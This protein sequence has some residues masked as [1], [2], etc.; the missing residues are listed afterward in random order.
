M[1]A[2]FISLFLLSHVRR[3]RRALCPTIGSAACRGVVLREGC[4][5]VLGMAKG[6]RTWH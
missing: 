3:S 1:L 4:R 2:G 6:K 5:G